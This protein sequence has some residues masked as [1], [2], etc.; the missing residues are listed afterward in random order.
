[1]KMNPFLSTDRMVNAANGS[2][3][4]Y[5]TV[6]RPAAGNRPVSSSEYIKVD[7]C[8]RITSGGRLSEL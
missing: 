4:S 1:M 5:M 6:N 3:R 2:V 7:L 8:T